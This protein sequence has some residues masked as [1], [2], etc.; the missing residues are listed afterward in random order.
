MLLVFS[1][2]LNLITGKESAIRKCAVIQIIFIYIQYE[3]MLNTYDHFTLS[4][5]VIV[6][7]SCF[8]GSYLNNSFNR[9]ENNFI[10][11]SIKIILS[12]I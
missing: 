4:S 12:V 8:T 9:L 11:S 3:A 5:K 7:V 6:I 10:K 2:S 1:P